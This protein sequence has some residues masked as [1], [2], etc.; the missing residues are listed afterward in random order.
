MQVTIF[1]SVGCGACQQAKAFLTKHGVS[2]VERDLAA[3]AAAV[4]ELVREGF[5]ALP[6]IRVNDDAL[7]GFNPAALLDLLS[8]NRRLDM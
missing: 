2:Y 4:D 6:V 8:R 3:D 5:R 1:T 7:Q